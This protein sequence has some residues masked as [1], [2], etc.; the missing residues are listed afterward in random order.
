MEDKNSNNML[1]KAIAEERLK[2]VPFLKMHPAIRWKS[3]SGCGVWDGS[4]KRKQTIKTVWHSFGNFAYSGILFRKKKMHR[5]GFIC[6]R[7]AGCRL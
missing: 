6:G 1:K 2:A 5:K 4:L 7:M 3:W